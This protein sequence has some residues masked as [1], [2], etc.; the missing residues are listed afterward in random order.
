MEEADGWTA[1]REGG[2][3]ERRKERG[4]W[5]EGEEED[6]NEN[7]G[8]L[9]DGESLEEESGRKGGKAAEDEFEGGKEE[10]EEEADR[11]RAEE[12]VVVEAVDEA[13]AVEMT[14][15]GDG[16]AGEE[17]VFGFTKYAGKASERRLSVGFGGMGNVRRSSLEREYLLSLC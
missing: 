2:V 15:R 16:T 1:G 17:F 8:E 5:E 10:K 6:E 14:C 11:V 12:D 3:E 7:R 4:E 13:A 9:E